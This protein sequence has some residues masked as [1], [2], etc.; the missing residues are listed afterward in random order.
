MGTSERKQREKKAMR[1]LIMDTAG[2]LFIRDGYAK[3]SI[4]SI[5]SVIEF[6]PGTIYLYFKNKD[7]IFHALHEAA[8]DKFLQKMS[9]ANHIEDPVERLRQ[10]GHIYIHFAFEN[11]EYYDLMFINRSPMTQIDE[12]VGW[13]CGLKSYDILRNTVADCINSGMAKTNDIE[14]MTFT[15][16][17]F[18]HGMAALGIR[19]RLKM[20]PEKNIQSFMENA[21]NLF[22][23][24]IKKD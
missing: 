17:S 18:V 9:N 10:L 16:W 19:D 7:E 13:S 2:K 22:T 4:R 1:K 11:P 20:Y 21:I 12:E 14:T 3:T 24:I 23:T 8:F 6:S 15:I 5:A